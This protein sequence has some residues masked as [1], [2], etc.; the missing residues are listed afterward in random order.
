LKEDGVLLLSVPI[1]R[2]SHRAGETLLACHPNQLRRRYLA[3]TTAAR[4][5][6]VSHDFVQSWCLGSSRAIA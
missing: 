6:R 1:A 3:L 2:A 5:Y 4:H